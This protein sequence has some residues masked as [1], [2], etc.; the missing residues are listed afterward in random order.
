M[1]PSPPLHIHVDLPMDWRFGRDILK[2]LLET[3][4]ALQLG[5]GVTCELWKQ[6]EVW[7]LQ[8]DQPPDAVVGFIRTPEVIQKWGEKTRLLNIGGII[9]EP[10]GVHTVTVDNL[11]VGRMAAD[12]FLKRGFRSFAYVSHHNTPASS[13]RKEGFIEGIGGED[14]FAAHYNLDPDGLCAFLKSLPVPTAVFCFQDAEARCVVSALHNIGRSVPEDF[15]VLGVNDDPI[16]NGLSA[17]PLSSIDIRAFQIG[18][19]TAETLNRLFQD[20]DVPRQQLIHPGELIV[21]QSSDI[22][23]LN[24]PV[25][26]DLLRRIRERAC[27]GIRVRDVMRPGDGSRRGME[28]KFKR[29]LG[30]TIEGEIRRCRLEAARIM[31][32]GSSKSIAEIA[33]AC[34]FCNP[35]HFS[36]MFRDAYGVPPGNYRS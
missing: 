3:S 13:L 1:K 12:H 34:G 36:R 9:D 8:K 35:P 4:R 22:F 31:L 16:D 30:R 28:M 11:E 7:S 17:V 27:E 2:G 20:E 33:D 23:A 5:W 25:V 6:E 19:L 32:L 21:R 29:M 24:D 14:Q 15:A 10:E 26:A 18:Q